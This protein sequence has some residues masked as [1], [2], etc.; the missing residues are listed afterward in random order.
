MAFDKVVDSVKLD[1]ALTET[2][3]AIREKV[4]VAEPIVF[5]EKQG[6]KNAIGLIDTETKYNQ[7]YEDGYEAGKADFE[8]GVMP[9]YTFRPASPTKKVSF[10]YENLPSEY[11]VVIIPDKFPIINAEHF[12]FVLGH[13][14]WAGTNE[15]SGSIVTLKTTEGLSTSSFVISYQSGTINISSTHATFL[16]E[17]TY[18]VFVIT[19]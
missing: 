6:F 4:S 14:S 11:S 3:N 10:P 5:D 8:G 2:A 18:N 12:A 13:Y 7:G 9:Y 15:Q 16:P 19:R 17:Y 1:G